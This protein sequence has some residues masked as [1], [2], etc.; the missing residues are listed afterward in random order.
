MGE[1][2]RR[3]DRVR[4]GYQGKPLPPGTKI[5]PPREPAADVPAKSKDSS[6]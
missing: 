4:E 3:K 6:K 5:V 2:Q 1:E